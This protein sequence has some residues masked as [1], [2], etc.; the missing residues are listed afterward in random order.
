MTRLNLNK[1]G[2]VICGVKSGS[3]WVKESNFTFTFKKFNIKTTNTTTECKVASTWH[4]CDQRAKQES[5]SV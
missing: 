1:L 5:K 3:N 2:A 4:K